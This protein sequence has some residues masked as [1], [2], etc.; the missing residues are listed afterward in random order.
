[1]T[2]DIDAYVKEVPQDVIMAAHKVK[3]WVDT[4]IP[5]ARNVQICG[6]GVRTFLS[7]DH[8]LVELVKTEGQ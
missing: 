4:N 8:M 7:T 3:R 2:N 1:M 5:S 6:V